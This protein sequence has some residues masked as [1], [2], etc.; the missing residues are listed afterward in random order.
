MRREIL[1]L[2]APVEQGDSGGPFVTSEGRVGGVIFAGDPGQQFTGYSV[3][4][5]QIRP[6]VEAA[7]AQNQ[8]VAVGDCRF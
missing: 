6:T 1:V 7:I 2:T 4:A 5:E 8:E 3:S